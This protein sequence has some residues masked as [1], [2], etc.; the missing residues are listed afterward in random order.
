MSSRKRD[1][2][3]ESEM[4]L[5]FL[6]EVR[7][8]PGGERI[9][10]CI[11]CGTCS[12]SC[13]T[14]FL[15]EDTPRRLFAM[16]R[17][18][19][20]EEVLKSPDIWLCTS[21]YSCYVRCPQSIKV[22]DIMYALKRLAVGRRYSLNRR[23]CQLGRNFLKVVN[24]YGRNHEPEL[25]LRYFLTANWRGLFTNALVGL[26]LFLKGRLPLFPK[27]MGD[28]KSFQAVVAKAETLA[29]G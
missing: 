24:R 3:R 22:T 9:V 27:G 20:R 19:M 23:G 12:G 25:L 4:D 17:A 6:E 7:A 10:D 8:I 14:S 5:G 11:Q 1:I 13:P 16:V 15:M 28:V 26:R 21:C 18:G 29:G 2:Q